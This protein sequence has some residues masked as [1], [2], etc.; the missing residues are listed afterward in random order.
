MLNL[1]RLD[2]RYTLRHPRYSRAGVLFCTRGRET[3]CLTGWPHLASFSQRGYLAREWLPDTRAAARI[4]TAFCVTELPYRYW[5][6]SLLCEAESGQAVIAEFL[7]T[8]NSRRSKR[9]AHELALSRLAAQWA[10]FEETVPPEF[11]AIAARF[12]RNPIAL[13]RLLAVC[14]EA[15]VLAQENA[16]VFFELAC[17]FDRPCTSPSLRPEI[18]RF[19]R[20][21]QAD[22]LALRGL[23]ATESARRLFRRI[24]AEEIC[25]T[26]LQALGRALL[27]PAI[28]RWL[29]HFT[30]LTSHIAVLLREE[31]L[32]PYL[33][34]Q[35]VGDLLTKAIRNASLE[36]DFLNY[37][38]PRWAVK[39][40][41]KRLRW[42]DRQ[43]RS[44]RTPARRFK[45]E[46]EL[47]KQRHLPVRFAAADAPPDL[48]P[49]PPPPLPG[50]SDVV[51]ITTAAEL[52]AEGQS[53][54]NCAGASGHSRM[55][56]AGHAYF[57]RVLAPERSTAMIENYTKLG[58]RDG[59]TIVELRA[60]AD[61]LPRRTT[62]QSVTNALGVPAQPVW[63]PRDAWWCAH[64][65]YACLPQAEKKSALGPRLIE[66][67]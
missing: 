57:Y 16:A 50:T 53:Q 58:D 5:T 12:R 35:L 52:Q 67:V 7:D 25:S 64:P 29:T 63:H 17:H 43:V 44:G 10:T 55:I 61:A 38:C 36:D 15:A 3:F 47:E 45:T 46:G 32:W 62:L 65:E 39:D 27:D 11:C 37:L 56:Q 2:R 33:T 8:G 6:Q 13:L 51:P 24:P 1:G 4:Y 19:L 54:Q 31:S 48:R 23:P 66:Q 49:F 18:L 41:L 60:F 14:P 34:P 42:F 26:H 40:T 28:G 30:P 59:W 20:G 21:P 9:G 22:I